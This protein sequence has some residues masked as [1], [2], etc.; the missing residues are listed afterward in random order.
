MVNVKIGDYVTIRN[1]HGVELTARVYGK[2][3][4]LWIVELSPE[5][6]GRS[7]GD[8]EGDPSSDGLPMLLVRH[9]QVVNVLPAEGQ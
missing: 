1:E 2:F 7:L 8:F 3:G 9:T 4:D 5:L 6:A